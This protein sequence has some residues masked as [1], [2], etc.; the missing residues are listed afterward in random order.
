LTTLPSAGVILDDAQF[1]AEL[2]Q[3]AATSGKT[4]EQAKVYARKC[5]TEIEATPQDAW[6]R[7]MSRLARF[8]YT[9]SYEPVLDINLE[10]LEELRTLSRDHL[11]LF[12]WSHKS[13]MDSFVFLL[14]LYQNNFKPLPLIFAG[15]NMNFLGFGALARR[16]GAIFLRRSFQEDPIYKLVFRRYIDFLIRNRMPLSWSIEGTRSRTGKLSPPKLGLL[17]WVVESCYREQ[18]KNVLLVPVSIAFDRIA[19]ID[20]YVA[21]Q[22]GLPKRKESLGWF[23]NYVFGMKQPYGKVYVRYGEP[24]PMEQ[25]PALHGPQAPEPDIDVTRMAFE[26]CTRIEQITPIKSADVLA[27][28]LLGAN[29]RALTA[30]EMHRQSAGIADLIR[31]RK[32]PASSGFSLNNEAEVSAAL[33]ALER[34]GLVKSFSAS[35]IP[36]YYIPEGQRL[37]AAYYRNTI[38]HYFMHAA[39]GEIGLAMCAL[40]IELPDAEVLRSNV[41]ALRELYKF[42]FFYKP[43]DEFW[44]EVL[45]ETG[46]RYPQ[47]DIGEFSIEKMLHDKPPRFGHAILR[48]ITEAYLIIAVALMELEE[49]HVDDQKKFIRQLLA[50]GKEMLLRRTICCESSVSQDLLGNGLRLAGH[51][52]L[53]EGRGADIAGR[54]VAFAESVVSALSAINLL[55]RAYDQAWFSQLSAGRISNLLGP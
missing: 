54:R 8:I 53:L 38:T 2:L 4:P 55:Q 25:L 10:K 11:L 43:A 15:I 20:D 18:T 9:R 34:S 24:L 39:L 47:W 45:V 1:Q 16:V 17:N 12:L 32:L 5:L 7:P 37:A 22:S 6:L 28:V 33:L 42:E 35:Q 52:G 21:L 26:V 14:S 40:G 51:L 23:F 44:Q 49:T 48:Q 19:E 3:A 31:E 30:S 36:V 50:Q 46:K 13:H 27:M 29:Y 41:G